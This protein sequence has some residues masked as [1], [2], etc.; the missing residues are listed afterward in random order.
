MSHQKNFVV[1]PE[2]VPDELFGQLASLVGAIG[3]LDSSGEGA[4]DFFFDY[5]VDL[6]LGF[7]REF[8]LQGWLHVADVEKV[9]DGA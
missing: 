6:G 4:K 1:L 3:Y 9:V 2:D 8:L 7:V 5:L